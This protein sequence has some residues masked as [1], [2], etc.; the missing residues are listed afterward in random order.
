MI[1]SAAM[2]LI[3]HRTC[4]MMVPD[5]FLT[6]MTLKQSALLSL[7]LNLNTQW[8]SVDVSLNYKIELQMVLVLESVHI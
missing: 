8:P 5:M 2:I 4:D 3:G 1:C 6:V 7:Y